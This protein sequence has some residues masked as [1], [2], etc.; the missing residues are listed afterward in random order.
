[1]A[2]YRDAAV[3]LMKQL[4]NSGRQYS[5][6]GDGHSWT[7]LETM[8]TYGVPVNMP[9]GDTDCSGAVTNTYI[10]LGV[11]Q[12][13]YYDTGN[14]ADKLCSQGFIYHTWGDSY[15]MRPG[16][17]ALRPKNTGMEYGHVAMCVGNDY[18][19]AE[20]TTPSA[21][22]PGIRSFY[23]YPWTIC[24]EL[25]DSIGN[26]TWSDSGSGGG[27]GGNI[28]EDGLWGKETTRA[29][30]NHY[31]TTPDG[32]V[33]HQWAPNIR[34][35]PVLVDGWLCDDTLLG[36]PVIRAI[37][38]NLGVAPVDGIM[39]Q[40]TITAINNL[41]AGNYVADKDNPD[42][43]KYLS[44]GA[45]WEIQHQLNGGVWPLQLPWQS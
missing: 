8:Y 14:M 31:G 6:D 3:D 7:N 11:L 18:T 17:L 27:T 12:A 44:T 24:L 36:S 34:E 41:F 30:Q 5:Y 23:N 38:S 21:G 9:A 4:V 28:D 19:L 39:G 35:N 1:M 42:T 40:D 22:G 2:T 32:E 20:F 25:P 43:Y 33:W 37:Q 15:V 13:G 10:A 26:M 29:L 45:V 16:D